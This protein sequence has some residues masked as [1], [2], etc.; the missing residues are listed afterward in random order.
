VGFAFLGFHRK[1]A[2]PTRIR[3]V[4]SKGIEMA[5]QLNEMP[6]SVSY[7]PRNVERKR[8]TQ[9]KKVYKSEWTAFTQILNNYGRFSYVNTY[10]A[11]CFVNHVLKDKTIRERYPRANSLTVVVELVPANRGFAGR[12]ISQAYQTRI[13]IAEDNNNRCVMLHELAHALVGNVERHGPVFVECY[14]FLMKKYYNKNAVAI[15]TK[16]MSLNK[17]RVMNAQGK[18]SKVREQKEKERKVKKV[19]SNPSGTD[20]KKVSRGTGSRAG[21]LC[22]SSGSTSKFTAGTKNPCPTCGKKVTTKREGTLRNH[23]GKKVTA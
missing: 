7:F 10:E 21:K 22:V 11:Q 13:Q 3:W 14:L 18:V 1:I 17:V 20:V 2:L 4:K 5:L 15:L 8:D 23:A 9:R 16:F 19:P 6:S 12:T